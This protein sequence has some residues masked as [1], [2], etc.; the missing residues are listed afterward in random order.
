MAD[1]T[2]PPGRVRG[3][4]RARLPG[5]AT[6]RARRDE[7]EV[8]ILAAEVELADAVADRSTVAGQLRIAELEVVVWTLRSLAASDVDTRTRCADRA[9]QASATA[10]RWRKM[11]QADHVARLVA[12]MD[13][14]DAAASGLEDL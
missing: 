12:R 10:A 1:P 5:I 3:R 9:A 4:P 11:L 6:D 8:R 7:L 2:K 14:Q 13:E